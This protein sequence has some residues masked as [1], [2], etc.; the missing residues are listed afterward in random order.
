MVKVDA[1]GKPVKEG[2][3]MVVIVYCRNCKKGKVSGP[4]STIPEC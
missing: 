3:A 2:D 1:A 4:P